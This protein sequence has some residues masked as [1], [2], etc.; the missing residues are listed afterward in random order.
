[1]KLFAT[2]VLIFAGLLCSILFLIKQTVPYYWGSPLIE[3]KIKHIAQDS[4]VYDNFFIGSSKTY[5]QINP[6]LFDR[7]TKLNS[8]NLGNIGQFYLESNYILDHFL[9]EY[10]IKEKTNI[11]IQEM[12]IS[13]IADGNLHTLKSKYFMDFKRLKIGV[14]YFWNKKDY[15]QVYRHILSFIE[16]KL[17]IGEFREIIDYHLK[18]ANEL[19]NHIQ[20][21][22]GF[23]SLEQEVVLDDNK[24]LLNRNK[25]FK[26]SNQYKKW[27]I[28]EELKNVRIKKITPSYANINTENELLAFHQFSAISL[29]AKYYFDRGHLNDKGVEIYTKKLGN[30]FNLLHSQTNAQ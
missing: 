15:T 13:K 28:N 3:K 10:P 21:Q 5:R 30:A 19:R 1:M 26:K 12:Q 22:N 11:L 9:E 16:N 2:K 24:D 6:E 8:Y 7:K 29:D 23:Y 20:E 4:K 14:K 25:F 27:K 17:C 18:D